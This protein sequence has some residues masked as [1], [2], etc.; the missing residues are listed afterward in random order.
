MQ[1]LLRPNATRPPLALAAL[2]QVAYSSGKKV[3]PTQV[4]VI[5]YKIVVETDWRTAQRSGFYRGSADDQRDGYIHLS[6][7]EQVEGTAARH[8]NHQSGLLLIAFDAEKL[9]DALRLERSRGG[10]LFPHLYAELATSNALWEHRMI[11]GED[12]VPRASGVDL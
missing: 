5:V 1:M 11:V 8:F 12:G 6:F 3:R 4:S 10:A 7:A 9:G 2:N